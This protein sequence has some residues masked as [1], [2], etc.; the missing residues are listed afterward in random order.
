MLLEDR[1]GWEIY[2]MDLSTYTQVNGTWGNAPTSGVLIVVEYADT[3]K[4]VY[5]GM[6]YYYMDPTPK[7]DI[8]A[9]LEADKDDYLFLPESGIKI[10]S[11]VDQRTWD[12]VHQDIFGVN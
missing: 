6:D 12:I 2:Y 1:I 11:W 10:G 5:M 4:E 8:N 3:H 9:Y 7:G